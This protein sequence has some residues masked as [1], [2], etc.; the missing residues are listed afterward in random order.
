MSEDDSISLIPPWYQ[1]TWTLAKAAGRTIFQ[2]SVF[3]A[4][5]TFLQRQEPLLDRKVDHGTKLLSITRVG[6]SPLKAKIFAIRFDVNFVR[7][8]RGHTSINPA[9][10]INAIYTNGILTNHGP[11][12]QEKATGKVAF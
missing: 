1:R 9:V 5:L 10:P 3:V 4:A 12:L 2:I 11:L 7:D 8:N 6:I